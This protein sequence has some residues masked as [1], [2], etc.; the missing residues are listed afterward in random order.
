LRPEEIAE[1]VTADLRPTFADTLADVEA[2]LRRF[3]VMSE[4]AVTI[5]VLWIA[6]VYSFAAFEFTPYLAVTSATKRSGKSRLLEVLGLM[7]G[8]T[9]AVFTAYISA[10]SLYRLIHAK[11]GVA[12]LWDEVDR[13]PKEKAEELWGLINSGW[14]LGGQVHRQT[15]PKMETLAPF[16][17][18]SPKVLAGIGRPLPDPVDDRS[19]KVR[20]ERRL[21]SER[22]ERLRLRRV[23]AEAA[24]IRATLE[25]WA[26]EETIKRL[27]AAEPV[28]P[29]T[30][31]NDRLLDVAEPLFAIADMA[32]DNWPARLRAAIE[33]QEGTARQVEEDELS[34]LALAHVFEA[35]SVKQA[36]RLFTDEILAYLITLDSGPWAE[37][38]GANVELGK[39][40]APARRLRK[41]LDRFDGIEPV[42]VRIGDVA[43]K[44][45]HLG[46]IQAAASRYL[47]VTRVTSETPLAST[48]S[49]VTDVAD[50]P[51]ND[52]RNPPRPGPRRPDDLAGPSGAPMR[53]LRHARKT[54]LLLLLADGE[55]RHVEELLFLDEDFTSVPRPVRRSLLRE[56]IREGL[57]SAKPCPKDGRRWDYRRVPHPWEIEQLEAREDA[58]HG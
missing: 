45:Y 4:H 54:C 29:S 56:L 24:P 21:P 51:R 57:V 11:P 28:L 18:F 47:S 36:D 32:G 46:P 1:Q 30:I 38:W 40:V 7:L 23:E 39:T 10:A 6:H 50:T 12:I 2:F 13:V 9:R 49:E 14:R 33:D 16:S 44:G 55:P 27:A 41:L 42:S 37:F 34:L 52:A 25:A 26:S 15:G 48:V 5:V 3:V 31:Q 17:T 58:I 43:K 35:F 8:A 53:T 19:L 22:V 20:M